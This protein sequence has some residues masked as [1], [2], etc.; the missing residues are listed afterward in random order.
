MYIYRL[1]GLCVH[2]EVFLPNGPPGEGEADLRVLLRDLDDEELDLEPSRSDRVWGSILNDLQF[3]IEGG[4]TI[5]IDNRGRID[6]A[7]IAAY[8]GGVLFATVLRQRGFLTLHASAVARDGQA[9]A[10]VG[11]SRWGKSTLAAYFCRMGYQLVNDD[12]LVIDPT[13]EPAAALS[14]MPEVNLWDDVGPALHN[15]FAAMPSTTWADNKRIITQERSIDGACRLVRL[16]LL[17][18]PDAQ[19]AMSRVLTKQEALLAFVCHSR[20][21]NVLSDHSDQGM[22]LT[23]CAWLARQVQ[24]VLLGHHR[25]PDR[26]PELFAEIEADIDSDAK[27]GVSK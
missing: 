1:Y 6:E 16:Y 18:P 24:T 15:D 11:E 25:S 7:R 12:L 17:S 20:V 22:N 14:G 26:L 21:N 27:A 10:F 2:S 13:A 23:N 3:L 5:V 9:I 4:S 8:L 19:Q